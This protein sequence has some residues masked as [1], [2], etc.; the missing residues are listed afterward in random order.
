MVVTRAKGILQRSWLKRDTTH[1]NSGSVAVTQNGEHASGLIESRTHLLD[2]TSEQAAIALSVSRKDPHVRELIT[3][4]DGDFMLNPIVV[5]V[6]ADHAR[7]TGTRIAYRVYDKELKALYSSDDISTL[8]YSPQALVLDKIAGWKPRANWMPV[9]EKRPIA[10]QLRTAALRGMETHFSSNTKT[11]YGAAVL[12]DDRIYFGGVYSSFDHRMNIHSE[13]VAAIA[14]I[15]DG[16]RNIRQVGLVSNKFVKE[17]PHL[18]GCCRQ[19]FSEIQEK[20]G[21]KIKAV[22]FSY[23]GSRTFDIMLDDYLPASWHSGKSLEER[24]HG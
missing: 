19:F 21:K 3:V 7:R 14:A 20:T 8:F 6:L 13:M 1:F 22:T 9:D 16:K 15:M 12:V 10:E 2:I 18:C 23:D 11:T 17:T 5:K 24:S 4:V